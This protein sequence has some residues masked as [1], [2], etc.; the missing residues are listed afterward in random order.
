MLSMR[1]VVV[2]N[3]L[4][5]S[6]SRLFPSNPT[7]LVLVRP[8]AARLRSFI[9]RTPTFQI[10]SQN[11]LQSGT[12]EQS[13]SLDMFGLINILYMKADQNLDGVIS[14]SELD[15]VY[16]GFDRNRD[17]V[18]S[19]TEF[20]SL[21]TAITQM[22][23]E[24]ATAFFLLADLDDNEQ[25]DS[26]DLSAI[27]QRFDLNGDGNV[28]AEEFNLKWQQLYHEAPIAVLYTEA[29]TNK[30][31]EL[32]EAEFSRLFS[33][34]T[35]KSDGSVTKADFESGWTKSIGFAADADSVFRLWTP[36]MMA[37][38]RQG[39]SAMHSIPLTSAIGKVF[40]TRAP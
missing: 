11:P 8:G 34:F 37:F 32:Q 27:Y 7:H 4:P 40:P 19:Q 16:T 20:T 25:I 10:L 33:P 39:K 13:H 21:W 29:D 6:S 12:S 24:E 2:V 31:D 3:N 9:I 22:T 38:S 18:I 35:S 14:R 26:N 15:S 1:S 28:Q 30:D 23:Q 17:K 36:T 5:S